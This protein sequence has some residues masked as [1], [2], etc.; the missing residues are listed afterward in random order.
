MDDVRVETQRDHLLFRK[1]TFHGLENVDAVF[2]FARK[3]NVRAG[4]IDGSAVGLLFIRFF[5]GMKGKINGKK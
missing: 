2:F 1:S 3:V 4:T 5:Q